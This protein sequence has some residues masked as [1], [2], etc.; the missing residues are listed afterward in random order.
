MLLKTK[1]FLTTAWGTFAIGGL[2]GLAF[3][4]LFYGLVVVNPFNTDWIWHSVTHDTAQHFIGWEF[5]R[6]DSTGGIIN[7]LAYPHG[8]AITFM[9]SIPLLAFIFKPLAGLLPANFQYFGLWALG[10]YILMGGLAAILVSRIWLRIF[11][12]PETSSNTWQILFVAAGSLLFVLSPILMA[13]TLYHPALAGQWLILWTF[14]FVWDAPRRHQSNWKFAAEQ[15]LILVLAVLIHPYFMPMLGAMMLVALIRSWRPVN[16]YYANAKQFIIKGILPI[17]TTGIAFYMVG[18]FTMGTGSEVHDLEEKGFNLLS[19]VNPSGYSVIPAFPNR[20]SS[21]E[22]MM[23][24]G[25][26]IIIM[27][28]MAAVLWIGRYRESLT[29][30]KQLWLQHKARHILMLAVGIGLLIFALGPRIDLGPITILQYPV[31]A[32]IY[33]IWS[34]FR[35]AAR[36]AWPFYYALVLLIIYWFGLAIKKRL[37]GHDTNHHVAIVIAI[38][39]AVGSLIQLTD[40]LLSP[41]ATAKHSGFAKISEPAEFAPLD[42]SG[43]YNKQKHLVA[44]D[45]SF[46]GDQAGTYIVARTALKYNMTLN[47]GFFARVQDEIK[48]EQATWRQRVQ[49]NKLTDDDLRDQLFFTRNQQLANQAANSYYVT[50]IDGFWFIY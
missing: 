22:T 30:L 39:L 49:Q 12:R 45:D 48:Q 8:L 26:G 16:G 20:S 44:L 33:D 41:A 21:P 11:R 23:W 32:K 14:I 5:F 36:E 27:A 47:T 6:A 24:L 1:K 18:G 4:A 7:G 50:K 9:D 40:I 46:R 19:F 31:P 28:L 34:A 10:C 38:S 42:L 25:L 37:A 35:A 3:F 2:I 13:R 29:H 43:I 17:I 15:C